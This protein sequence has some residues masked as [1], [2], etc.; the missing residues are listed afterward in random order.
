MG[1]ALKKTQAGQTLEIPAEAYNAFIDA[2]RDVRG[3]RHDVA[4]DATEPLRQSG[5]VK[6]RNKSGG[7][8]DRFDILM[9]DDPIIGPTDNLQQYKNQVAFEGYTPSE[10]AEPADKK[11]PIECHK[12]VV[13][14]EPL[15]VDGIGRATISGV[16]VARVNVI[17]ETDSFADI[18]IGNTASLRSVPFGTTSILWKEPGLGVKWA[19]VR[20]GDRPRLAIFE[21][22]GTWVP[23]NP[24]ADPPEPDGWAKMVG[25]RPV[26]YFDSANTYNADTSEPA[27]TVWHAVGYPPAERAAVIALHKSTGQLPAK[28]GC[29]D[30]VWCH[31]NDHECRWQV[32]SPYEDHWRFKLLTP[33]GSLRFRAGSTRS[34][35]GWQVVSGSADVHGS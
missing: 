5:I 35:Q 8:R 31:W 19:V 26:F 21:L 4:Q 12:F 16:S 34:L 29:G 1:D 11:E 25:C 7:D 30:W 10:Q 27:Q 28:F 14:L 3:R 23:G 17:R 9:I 6:V 18:E 33:V 32:L 15:P 2:V 13:L 22:S 24:A 20:L